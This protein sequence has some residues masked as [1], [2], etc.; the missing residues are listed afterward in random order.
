MTMEDRSE[1]YG[2]DEGKN[3][4]EED[5]S[6]GIFVASRSWKGKEMDSPTKLP[7]WSW[8][9][10]LRNPCWTSHLKNYIVR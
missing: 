9:L 1:R 6:Q 4:E 7:E 2:A 5:Q 3:M 8:F 10:A